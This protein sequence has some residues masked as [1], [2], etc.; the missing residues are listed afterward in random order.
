MKLVPFSFSS[1][2]QSSERKLDLFSMA[3]LDEIFKQTGKFGWFQLRAV[4]IYLIPT[5]LTSMI[6]FVQVFIAGEGDHWCKVSQWEQEG[7]KG[8]WNLTTQ[9]CFA[10]MRNRSTPILDEDDTRDAK[11]LKYEEAGTSV[12]LE[13]AYGNSLLLINSSDVISC[14]EGW[15]FDSSVY[16]S[17]ISEDVSEKFHFIDL[18]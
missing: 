7:C 17:T 16:Q 18:F 4:L 13:E 14:D 15:N 6:T 10:L 5:I 12:T 11:C 3:T 9:E 2:F 1:T 8:T